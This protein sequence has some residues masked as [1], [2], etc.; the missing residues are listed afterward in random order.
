MKSYSLSRYFV[1]ITFPAE[2]SSLL[3]GEF[4][5]NNTLTIGGQG[6]YMDKI[7]ISRNTD[8]WSIKG[9]STGSYVAEKNLD[10]T[11]SCILSLSQ[12][13]DNVMRFM[14]L[15]NIFYNGDGFS[16]GL[17]ITVMKSDGS[18]EKVAVCTDCL[19]KKPADQDFQGE[20]QTQDWEFVCGRVDYIA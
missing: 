10:A 15:A 13:S 16:R 4:G 19:I 18:Q 20:S 12:L 2:L 8:T 17:T 6:S 14:R 11:G 9:D 1:S 5:S 3:N 7:S